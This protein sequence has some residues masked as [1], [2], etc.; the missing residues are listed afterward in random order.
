M[1]TP[2]FMSSHV[3]QTLL[4]ANPLSGRA[5]KAA[6]EQTVGMAWPEEKQ[7]QQTTPWQGM[8]RDG[9]GD[10]ASLLSTLVRA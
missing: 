9:K 5:G 7:Q 4:W 10:K 6:L 8:A 3:W 1:S 2:Y